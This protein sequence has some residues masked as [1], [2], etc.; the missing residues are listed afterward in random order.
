MSCHTKIK[1]LSLKCND[2]TLRVLRAMLR[3]LCCTLNVIKTTPHNTFSHNVKGV[4]GYARAR[5]R[6]EKIYPLIKKIKSNVCF[7]APCARKQPFTPITPLTTIEIYKF[8]IACTLN[9]TL[10]TLNVFVM[11]R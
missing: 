3:V 5:V 4:K 2:K 9:Y 11:T 6:E 8:F 7:F 1:S 10:N